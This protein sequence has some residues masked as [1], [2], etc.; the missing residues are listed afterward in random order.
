MPH[1][2]EGF[3]VS[4][5]NRELPIKYAAAEASYFRRPGMII[6]LQDLQGT[7]PG[8]WI[9]IVIH[10][11][12][13]RRARPGTAPFRTFELPADNPVNSGLHDGCLHAA[14]YN[15]AGRPRQQTAAPGRGLP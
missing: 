5:R 7:A 1:F 11:T 15:A 8:L 3:T 14:Q 13:K 6:L 4:I 12:F 2:Y 10:S 9:R